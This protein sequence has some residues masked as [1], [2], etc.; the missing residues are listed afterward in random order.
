M[1]DVSGNGGG[2]TSM[3]WYSILL[4]KPYQEEYAKYRRL[5]AYDDLTVASEVPIDSAHEKWFAS[6]ESN[7]NEWHRIGEY[8]PRLPMFC[9]DGDV[10]CDGVLEKPKPNDFTGEVSLIIDDNCVSS[11]SGLAGTF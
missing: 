5:Q 4:D 11:Y 1:I 6:I 10:R 8:L 3:A 9:A 2:D 7:A